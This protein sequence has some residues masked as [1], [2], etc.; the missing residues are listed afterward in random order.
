[1]P[2]PVSLVGKGRKKRRQYPS[3]WGC[4]ADQVKMRKRVLCV[5]DGSRRLMKDEMMLDSAFEVRMRL[6]E[7]NAYV[8]DLDVQTVNRAEAMHHATDEEKGPEGYVEELEQ[9]L[10]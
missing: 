4:S 7:G 2:G 1:M 10:V 8:T 9:L 5:F 3:S 6:G